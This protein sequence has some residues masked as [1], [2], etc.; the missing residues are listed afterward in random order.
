MRLWRLRRS[1][2]YL[3][4]FLFVDSSRCAPSVACRIFFIVLETPNSFSAQQLMMLSVMKFES[5]LSPLVLK[6]ENL[7]RWLH[8]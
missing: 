8:L 6:V 7:R 4:G 2:D 5:L 3:A 1:A